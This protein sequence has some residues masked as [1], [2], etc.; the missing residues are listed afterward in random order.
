MRMPVDT[1]ASHSVLIVEDD[2][3]IRETLLRLLDDE[4]YRPSACSNGREAIDQLRDGLH[5]DVILLDL[6]MPVMDG[7]E[8]RL[9]QKADPRLAAIPVMALSADTSAKAAAIDADAYL[10]KCRS[11][12]RRS[13]AAWSERSSP[14]SG[15]SSAGR[16]RRRSGSRRSGRS[17]RAWR[18]R[19]TTR[20]R[21]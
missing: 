15:G 21:T 14:P 8:F 20:S 13:S 3:D 19:S 12:T 2:D 18:T 9:Q 17:R 5:A 7:W 1:A 10:R 6:M 4:G 11:T 16:S